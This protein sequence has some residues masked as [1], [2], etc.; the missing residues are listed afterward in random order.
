MK[1]ADIIEQALTQITD[2]GKSLALLLRGIDA[3]DRS[4]PT[5]DELNEAFIEVERRGCFKERDWSQVTEKNYNEAIAENKE[6][7]IQMLESQ[8][9]SPENQKQA[10]DWHRRLWENEGI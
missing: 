3:L 9:I 10:L 7:M 1:Y 2:S 6:W 8:G 4:V 5:L